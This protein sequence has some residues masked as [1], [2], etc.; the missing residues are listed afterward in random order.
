MDEPPAETERDDELGTLKAVAPGGEALMDGEPGGDSQTE[1]K[2]DYVGLNTGEV[3]VPQPEKTGT[4]ND[5]DLLQSQGIEIEGPNKVS[6]DT[7]S[8]VLNDRYDIHPSSPL[9]NLDS[10]SAHA[11][12]AESLTSEGVDVFA[13]VCIPDL[14]V[15]VDVIK[16][17]VG[18]T[19]PSCLDL[20]DYGVAYWPPL[21][22]KTFILIF[23]RPLGG[24][25]SDI[26][27]NEKSDYNK[28]DYIKSC[29]DAMII[30]LDELHS[31]DIYHRAIR[32]DNLFFRDDQRQDVVL[33]EFVS[34]PPGFDQPI[35]Y[36]T[37]ERSMADEGGR[38]IGRAEDDMYACGV[39]LAVMT[40][41][42]TPTPS[43]K[44]NLIITKITDTSYQ[45]LVGNDLI[46]GTLLDGVRGLLNDDPSQRWGL[47]E[48]E[49]WRDGRRAP[50]SPPSRPVKARKPLQIDGVDHIYLRT[51][52]YAAAQRPDVALKL[53]K[54]GTIPQWVRQE[55]KD[56]DLASI[57]E[58]LTLQAET[59]PERPETD[60][61]LIAQTLIC[62]DPQAPVRFKGVSFMPE[63]IGTAM[64]IERL[65]GGKL[66]PFAEAINFEIAKRWFEINTETSA[67]RD[68]KAAG[69]LSMRSHL[70]DKNPGYGIERCLYEMN[71]GFPCQSPLLQGEFIINLEDL[72]PALEETA[73]TVDPKTISVDR[74]IAAFVA[75][76][77]K[78]SVVPSLLDIANPNEAIK[79][80]GQLKLLSFVQDLSNPQPF[81][82]LAKWIG[83]QI[84]PVIQLYHHRAT[85]KEL[86]S[87]VPIRVQSGMLS[88][89]LELLD[90]REKRLEDEAGYE[91]AIS[92][93]KNTQDEIAE[94]KSGIDPNSDKA[95]QSAQQA[96]AIASM[97]IMA[98][99]VILMLFTA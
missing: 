70:R 97:V 73:K 8:I 22:R 46:T 17:L 36:E 29:I 51:M 66:M 77:V 10:P 27:K 40:Q 41:K 21:E 13:L 56:E 80:L 23:A 5:K 84:E 98:F 37:I 83:S 20:M 49:N 24:R 92:E 94:I 33:G 61:V 79:V 50:T 4:E 71:Q 55:L 93:F 45:T 64:M 54:D 35:A 96:S 47:E 91:R 63:A 87:E 90:N 9:P 25:V 15:R 34:S 95:D 60:H 99:V 72:L 42:S 32:H 82:A 81:P 2:A 28:I 67:S 3:P 30:G 52:A 85:R 53:I 26:L 78:N 7:T 65:R 43:S 86:S 44:E 59:N 11:F 76:R 1:S 14:A 69:Y 75:S 6:L 57:I 74:H 12:E 16:K 68:M 58:D 88:D 19:I 38:G 39:A 31:R 89:L 18:N 48:L 62:L